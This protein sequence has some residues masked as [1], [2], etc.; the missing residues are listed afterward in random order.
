M[1]H[2]DCSIVGSFSNCNQGNIMSNNKDYASIA[3]NPLSSHTCSQQQCRIC[4]KRHHTLLHIDKQNQA[5]NAN[6]TTTNNSSPAVT[7]GKTSAEGNTY[8]TFKGKPRN[9]VI[10][11]TAVVEVGGKTGH[12]VPCRALL[13]DGSETHFITEKCVQHLKLPRT[14][15]HT[16]IQGI[17]NVNTAIQH[18]ISLHL[19]SR[20]RLAHNTRLCSLNNITGTTPPTRLDISTWKI[21]TDINLADK[22]FNQPGGIDLLIGAD[23][24]YKMLQPGRQTRPGDYPVLQETVLGWTVAGR[25][26]ANTTLEDVKH[27]FLLGTS[28]LDHFINQFWEAESMGLTTKTPRQKAGEEHLHTHN[29]TERG[30]VENKHPTRMESN[31]PGTSR[32][33][34]GQGPQATDIK[35]GQGPKLKVQNNNSSGRTDLLPTSRACSSAN[36]GK[37]HPQ[38]TNWRPGPGEGGQPLTTP[39]ACRRD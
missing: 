26:P 27:V 22:Y 15:R 13:D 31:Q 32:L 21:P 4:H 16:S 20:H 6:R 18:S 5:V 33:S 12:Y 1:V 7:K 36:N 8:H 25:T 24:F 17:S 34:E 10:L 23:I 14:Q 28:K 29:P 38:S 9:H 19:R 30:G 2:T 35:L 3:C 39:L 11:A 37:G